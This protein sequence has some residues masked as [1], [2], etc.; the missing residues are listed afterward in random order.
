[1][2]PPRIQIIAAAVLF[3]ALAGMVVALVV[4]TIPPGGPPTLR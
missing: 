1:M 2:R 3:I 4:L